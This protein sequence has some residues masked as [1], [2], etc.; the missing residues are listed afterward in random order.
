LRAVGRPAEERR[1]ELV[2]L[3]R[4]LHA[5]HGCPLKASRTNVVF[6]MGN[7]DAELMF[8]GEAP[9]RDEDLQGKP[10][11]GRAGRLLDQLLE[12]IGMPRSEVFVANVLKCLR[13]DAQVQLG[14]GSWERIGRLVRSRY[15]G[16]VMSVDAD[17][18]LVRRRVTG[19]H[20]TPLAGR[21]VYHLTYRS[22]KRAGAG[23][24]GI[25]LTGDHPVLTER[26]YV[27]VCELRPGDRVATGQGLSPLAR[28]VVCGTVLGDASLNASSAHLTMSHSLRQTDYATFK[29]DLLQ[30]LS[31]IVQA[32]DVAAVAGGEPSYRVVQVRTLAHRALGVL[33]REFY[34]ERKRVPHWLAD[35][36]SDRMLAFWFMDDGYLRIR[37]P[38]Q[39]SAEIA[40]N[41]FSDADRQVLLQGLRGLGL[42]AK[43]LRGRI[44]FDVR[45]TRALSERIAPYVPPVMRY[46]LD[47]EIEARIPFDPDRFQDDAPVVMYDDVEVEDITDRP[48]NDRTFFCIDVEETH[49]FVT[50]GGVVHN[51][52]PPGNR[53]PLPEEIEECK[54]YLMRQIQLIEPKMICTLGNFATKTITGSPMGI[55]KVC[56]RPQRREVAGLELTIYPLFH[57][58]AALRSTGCLND[59]REHIARIP[60]LLAQLREAA[61]ERQQQ[62]PP[63]PVGVV[64]A[65]SDSQLGLFG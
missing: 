51:C 3:Y 23:R 24:V 47:P 6:G 40:A 34:G 42:P 59:L 25:Q 65:P 49:N 57:P 43:A 60:E 64:A 16:D 35:A 17:G 9:G 62:S 28:D 2:E 46:K 29:A 61:A 27:P 38:R 5:D 48:R 13:Y 58:A 30:E 54:P 45:T 63:E 4:K 44:F 12:E 33:R 36:L 26:G 53:D 21:S 37:P 31:P 50:A 15:D 8:V 22:A 41:G 11:V 52:R 39:P 55:T 19:W 10:F 32:W 20:Q 1:A 7:A 56:G 14:D 18:R